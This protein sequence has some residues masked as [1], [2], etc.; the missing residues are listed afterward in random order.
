[1]DDEADV[2]EDEEGERRRRCRRVLL[3]LGEIGIETV[4]GLTLERNELWFEMNTI[5]EIYREVLMRKILYSV[6]YRLNCLPQSFS[7]DYR[8]NPQLDIV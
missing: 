5:R 1:M 3:G 4:I 7:Q 2:E 6:L 8:A